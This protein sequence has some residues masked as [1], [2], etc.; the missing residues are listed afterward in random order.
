[1]GCRSSKNAKGFAS[2]LPGAIVSHMTAEVVVSKINGAPQGSSVRTMPFYTVVFSLDFNDFMGTNR[3]RKFFS[4]F[5][6]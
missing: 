5:V 1:M 4:V 3:A 6:M 2:R